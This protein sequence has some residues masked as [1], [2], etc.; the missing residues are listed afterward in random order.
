M[1]TLT[2][3][4]GEWLAPGL[5]RL[6]LPM[7][8]VAMLGEP[9]G[10][11]VL[12]DAGMPGTAGTI[13]RAARHWH[14]ERPP[15]AVVLT[16]GHL[17]HIGA[18]RALLTHWRVPVYAHADE[19]PMLTGEVAYPFPDP[20]VGGVMSALS[21]AFVP[22]PFDFRP[23]VRPLPPG[24][25]PHAPDWRWVHTP[26]HT[27][28]H[29]SLWRE[30][31]RSLIAGDAFVTTAQESVRGA[32]L[33]RPVGVQGPPAYYT[34]NWEAARGSVRALAALQPGLA[35][36]GHGHP[37]SGAPLQRQ[38]AALAADFDRSA[39]PPRGWYLRHPQPAGRPHAGQPDPLRWWVLGGVAVAAA[40]LWRLRK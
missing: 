10:E 22:G 35:L 13:L 28:G 21:P 32:L 40:A 17:D 27:T 14:G 34:P 23:W 1:N 7:V 33:L 37:V 30:S 39:R 18:L 24:E 6:Q 9:G 5:L 26:G 38:L 12:V 3:A 15:S 4:P 20:T 2:N 31:D 29:V 36:T 8:N 11:W 16:H 25:L 19:L